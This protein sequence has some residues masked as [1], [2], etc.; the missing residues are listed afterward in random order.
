MQ[1][2]EERVIFPS[3]PTDPH[4]QWLSNVDQVIPRVIS[5]AAYYYP[6]PDAAKLVDVDRLAT[7]LSETLTLYPVLAGRLRM[8]EKGALGVEC[9]DAGAL[10]VMAMADGRLDEPSSG[11]SCHPHTISLPIDLR[12]APSALAARAKVREDSVARGINREDFLLRVKVTTFRCGGVSILSVIHHAIADGRPMAEFMN[13]WAEIAR[14]GIETSQN[15]CGV[16]KSPAKVTLPPVHDRSLL[17]PRAPPRVQRPPTSLILAPSSTT[18]PP[19]DPAI[20]K[21]GSEG[22][23]QSGKEAAAY[24][25][26]PTPPGLPDMSTQM[27][28]FTDEDLAALKRRAAEDITAIT[29]FEPAHK[30]AGDGGHGGGDDL[31]AGGETRVDVNSVFPIDPAA[32]RF[33]TNDVLMAHLWKCVSR[34][35]GLH[36][37]K[38]DEKEEAEGEGRADVSSACSD[39]WQS[40][41]DGKLVRLGMAVDG[42]KRLRPCLPEGYFGNAMFWSCASAPAGQ[43]VTESLGRTAQRIHRSVQEMVD[44]NLRDTIDWIEQ[45]DDLTAIVPPFRY[46]MGPDLICSN[47]SH[48]PA[49]DC[50][51]GWGP[52]VY[53]GH[54][55]VSE[56]EGFIVITATGKK[57]QASGYGGGGLFDLLA[58]PESSC[59][60][61][62]RLNWQ[63]VARWSTSPAVE[64]HVVACWRSRPPARMPK[65]DSDS[66]KR[67]ITNS[68]VYLESK[69][70]EQEAAMQLLPPHGKRSLALQ[71]EPGNIAIEVQVKRLR[72][73][74]TKDF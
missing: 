33:T 26:I 50:D 48:L 39:T 67:H 19:P 27:W 51:F 49:Y 63:E 42:R 5:M 23:L 25:Q 31:G 24:N 28:H 34:A 59:R 47:W 30:G 11:L 61:A 56:F 69:Q 10:L 9:N 16:S 12:W 52:P 14:R 20:A 43:L 3:I 41:E 73:S 6:G 64:E 17:K 7:S 44:D 70:G 4:V 36:V 15:G 65:S 60:P 40:G 38:A 1:E 55:P 21:P 29:P 53:F 13:S 32:Q 46:F 35:R 8:K 71:P 18:P 62:P 66:V 72:G 54:P 45:Q 2:L 22:G 58:S 57:K 37:S 74:A 68:G